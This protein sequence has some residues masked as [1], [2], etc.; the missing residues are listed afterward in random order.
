MK[1]SNKLVIS[2]VFLILA[3]LFIYDLML[4]T[5]FRTGTYKIPYRNYT[6]LKFKDFD[7]INVKSVSAA[8]VRFEQ[9]PFRVRIAP[10]ADEFTRVSQDKKT[11][12]IEAIFKHDYESSPNDYLVIISCPK[13]AQLKTSAWYGTNGRSYIDTIVNDQWN[14]RKVLVNGFKQDSLTIS[15]DYGSRVFLSNSRIGFL[16]AAIGLSPKSGSQLNILNNNQL[17]NINLNIGNRSTLIINSVAGSKFNYHL[18]DS[19]RVT[20]AGAALNIL[21]KQ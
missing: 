20:L 6:E 2:A 7:T 16:K 12:N 21:K 19:A 5:E 8:N 3:S 18:A 4:R 1:T 17:D 11:L 15:Q 13:I 9:G 10:R 14:M